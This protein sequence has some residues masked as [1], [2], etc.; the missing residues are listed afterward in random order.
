MK[1]TVQEPDFIMMESH[2]MHDF[3]SKKT[4]HLPDLMAQ[5]MLPFN[6]VFL[7]RFYISKVYFSHL[8]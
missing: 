7:W 4:T 3:Q 6:T 2:S 8:G 1:I 5:N